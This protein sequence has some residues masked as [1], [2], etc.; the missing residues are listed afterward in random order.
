[1][2]ESNNSLKERIDMN[3]AKMRPSTVK[4]SD[5]EA[6]GAEARKTK[7]PEVI[8]PFQGNQDLPVKTT[9]RWDRISVVA[10]MLVVVGVLAF[11]ALF[12]GSETEADNPSMALEQQDLA[13][14]ADSPRSTTDD[15]PEAVLPAT[16][17]VTETSDPV[18]DNQ[19]ADES[20][21]PEAEALATGSMAEANTLALP[22]QTSIPTSAAINDP[23]EETAI[24]KP[25]RAP[26]RQPTALATRDTV[27]TA[28]QTRIMSDQVSR[29]LITNGL[30]SREPM[31]TINDIR[32][33]DPVNGVLSVFAFSDVRGLRGKALYYRWINGEKQ[34]A[35]VRV[36]V[37]SDRWRS[38]S[39]KVLNNRMQGSWRVELK[40]G[41]GTLLAYTEFVY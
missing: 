34:V 10:L 37:G 28:G 18:P 5:T 1:M 38:S 36:G 41:D 40:T 30:S 31:G 26:V 25:D 24:A 13:G 33:E 35:N 9:Y 20:D 17:G 8:F 27:L 16:S 7:A 19:K 15:E 39:S 29:F 32:L 23:G 11:R 14:V 22:R 21:A 3:A 12:S 2:T 6:S 4:T